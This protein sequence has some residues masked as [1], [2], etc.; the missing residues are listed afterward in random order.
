MPNTFTLIASTTLGSNTAPVTFSSIPQT[1]KDLVFLVSARGTASTYDYFATYF[2]GDTGANYSGNM[3]YSSGGSAPAAGGVASV[4]PDNGGFVPRIP[5]PS[6][7]A[8]SF[9]NT[10]VYI[11][12]YTGSAKKSYRA[13]SLAMQAS[14]TCFIGFTGNFWNSTAA[15]TS[16]SFKPYDVGS[17]TTGSTFYLYGIK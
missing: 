12:N 8:A 9:S 16:V 1:F 7:N 3:L 13:E 14:S 17:F 6:I 5:A 11:P 15:I 10:K 2:N 4:A